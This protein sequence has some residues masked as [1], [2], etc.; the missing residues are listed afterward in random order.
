MKCDVYLSFDGNC[1]EAMNFYK[2]IFD[3]EIPIVMRYKDGPPEYSQP[4]IENK[5]MHTTMTFGNGCELKASD[6]FHMPVIKG[7]NFH[8]S[9]AADDEEQGSAIYYGLLEGGQSTMPFNDVF[10]GGKFGSVIDKFGVQWMVSA[11]SNEANS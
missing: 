6:D 1:E 2:D 8:V 11:P 3:G 10:W 4:E 5:V 7:S 9:I